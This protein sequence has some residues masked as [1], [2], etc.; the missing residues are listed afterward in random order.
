MIQ[1]RKIAEAIEV[2]FLEK[3]VFT[4]QVLAVVLQQVRF[5]RVV[6]WYNFRHSWTRGQQQQEQ[7]QLVDL[8][9]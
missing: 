6:D 4:T 8:R 2:C 3:T 9:L 5:D 1:V 7:Q